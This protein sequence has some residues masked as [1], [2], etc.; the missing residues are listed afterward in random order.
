MEAFMTFMKYNE[1]NVHIKMA[2]SHC[3]LIKGDTIRKWALLKLKWSKLCET[4]HR[5]QPF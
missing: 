1:L 4:Y 3:H 2:I 5:V